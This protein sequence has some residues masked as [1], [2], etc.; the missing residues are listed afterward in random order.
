MAILEPA[1]FVIHIMA[2]LKPSFLQDLARAIPQFSQST[3]HLATP[4]S[5]LGNPGQI[6]EISWDSLWILIF[7]TVQKKLKISA[8]Y[9]KHRK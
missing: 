1:L 8:K 2:I 3:G 6:W 5:N 7:G 9:G 4:L